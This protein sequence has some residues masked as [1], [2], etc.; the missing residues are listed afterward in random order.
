MGHIR[1]GT[2]PTSKKWREVVALLTGDASLEEIAAAS[3]KAAEFELKRASDDP[4][5]QFVAKMMVE[6]PLMA[7]MPA[8]DAAGSER[9]KGVDVTS[10]VSI[11]ALLS[12]VNEAIDQFTFEN[13]R[14]SDIGLIA[15]SAL[16]E[17]LSS[18]LRDNVPSLFTP[19]PAEIRSALGKYAGGQMFGDFAREFFARLTYKSLDYF[20]SRE[21]ANHTGQGARFV[22]DA[23]RVH[24]QQ[25][26]YQ[27]SFEASCIVKEYAGGWYGKTVWRDQALSDDAIREFTK[28]SFKKMRSELGRRA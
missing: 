6:L 8:I 2:L 9:I 5:F 12:S 25:A 4:V 19:E 21:L 26:L 18:K 13:G 14:S 3:S 24:F 1:L 11:P 28:F 7:R 10:P 23:D 22:T 15:Q 27:H 20:L 17:T 16:I